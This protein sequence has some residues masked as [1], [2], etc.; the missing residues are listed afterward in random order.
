M[1]PNHKEIGRDDIVERKLNDGRTFNIVKI[2]YEQ[3]AL[4]DR[5]R[6]PGWTGM[7]EARGDFSFTGA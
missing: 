1:A 2:F 7:C 3:A 5:L 6:G 4:E